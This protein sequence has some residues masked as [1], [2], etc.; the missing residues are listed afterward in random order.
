MA[1]PSPYP[2]PSRREIWSWAMFDFANSS[3]T[4]VIVSVAF[5]IYFTAI[6]LYVGD[7]TSIGDATECLGA[8]M[9]EHATSYELCLRQSVSVGSSYAFRVSQSQEGN[10]G[11]SCAYNRYALTLQ[12][13]MALGAAE[14]AIIK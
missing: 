11:G 10:C 1:E 7:G 14:R 12:L 2:P 4:T 9:S 8:P 13:G 5:G 3:Y 6:Q